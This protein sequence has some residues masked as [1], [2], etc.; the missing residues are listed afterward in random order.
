MAMARGRNSAAK[1]AA[2]RAQIGAQSLEWLGLGSFVVVALAAATSY[3]Q[4][5]VGA[6]LGQFL[7][8]HIKSAIGG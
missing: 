4:G 8:D 7:V 6:D 1:R 5:H 3:A 2:R